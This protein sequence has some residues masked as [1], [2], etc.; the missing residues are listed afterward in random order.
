MFMQDSCKMICPNCGKEV[1][2][3]SNKGVKRKFCCY[4][5]GYKFLNNKY[6]KEGRY[7]KKHASTTMYSL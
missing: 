2:Q 1:K 4:E 6:K 3:R 5:C 7:K